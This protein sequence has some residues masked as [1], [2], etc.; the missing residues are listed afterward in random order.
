MRVISVCLPH[1]VVLNP[2]YLFSRVYAN[3]CT[4][5]QNAEEAPAFRRGEESGRSDV[6]SIG[7][8]FSLK[9]YLSLDLHHVLYYNLRKKG[10]EK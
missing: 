1:V 7:K 4:S 6:S 2:L 10:G 9:L 3:L 8:I 5:P